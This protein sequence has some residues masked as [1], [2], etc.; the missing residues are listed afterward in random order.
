[1]PLVHNGNKVGSGQQQMFARTAVYR[2]VLVAIKPI[3]KSRVELTRSLLIELKNVST[4]V[5]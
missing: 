3:E 2:G 5:R 4:V 1:M